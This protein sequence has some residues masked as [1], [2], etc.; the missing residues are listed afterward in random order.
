[1]ISYQEMPRSHQPLFKLSLCYVAP[2]ILPSHTNALQGT[3]WLRLPNAQARSCALMDRSVVLQPAAAQLL[4][5][6]RALQ[7]SHDA[8]GSVTVWRPWQL[9]LLHCHRA[10]LG[11]SVPTVIVWPRR[12]TAVQ[13]HHV[14][15]VSSS[16]TMD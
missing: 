5:L 7:V 14:H 12:M 11:S 16:V 6:V 1:M 15:R 10:A 8:Q 13:Y 4:Q 2:L 3:V 9:A